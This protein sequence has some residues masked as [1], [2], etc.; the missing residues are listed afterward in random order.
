M[1]KKSSEHLKENNMS[2]WEHF[3]FACGH[4]LICLKA[5]LL[6]I[7][8]SIIPGLFPRTGSILVTQLSESFTVHETFNIIEKE[9]HKNKS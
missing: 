3:A 1:I 2:Y 5:G 7:I 9:I 8:H 6:L 4:G